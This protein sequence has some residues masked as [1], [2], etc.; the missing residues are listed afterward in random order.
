MMQEG[1]R[2]FEDFVAP[3]KFDD[4]ISTLRWCGKEEFLRHCNFE[5]SYTFVEPLLAARSW[6]IQAAVRLER[7]ADAAPTQP[8]PL[9]RQEHE[10]HCSAKPDYLA[11]DMWAGSGGSD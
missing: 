2:R 5:L 4:M 1:I 3:N 11:Q 6:I 7:R 8:K 10:N 9:A